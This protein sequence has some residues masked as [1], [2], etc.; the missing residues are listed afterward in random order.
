MQL[1]L[2]WTKKQHIKKITFD[3]GPWIN[4]VKGP[5]IIDLTN[6]MNWVGLSLSLALT[7]NKNR[8]L[9]SHEALWKGVLCI[10]SVICLVH[11]KQQQKVSSLWGRACYQT[12]LF[13][14]EK[15]WSLLKSGMLILFDFCHDLIFHKWT[16]DLNTRLTNWHPNGCGLVTWYNYIIF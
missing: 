12:K 6:M 16:I 3:F 14:C 5:K 11:E 7:P 4:T 8:I 9:V 2:W 13:I 10:L 15:G 1:G